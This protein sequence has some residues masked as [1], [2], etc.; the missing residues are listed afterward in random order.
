MSMIFDHDPCI[1]SINLLNKYSHKPKYIKLRKFSDDALQI[2]K[3][4]ISN[5]DTIKEI[6]N[7][8]STDPNNTFN[9][10]LNSWMETK[11]KHFPEITAH[12]N[13]YKYKLNKWITA[14]ILNSI[15]YREN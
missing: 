9:I 14:G 3:E 6:D 7:N 8:L 12:F 11:D 1:V 15:Q 2:Y 10:L 4:Q 13:K 5:S